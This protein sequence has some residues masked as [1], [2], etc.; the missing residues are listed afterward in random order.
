MTGCAVSALEPG[1]AKT[2]ALGQHAC[3][4]DRDVAVI[5]PEE[6]NARVSPCELTRDLTRA[7]SEVHRH[8]DVG[9]VPLRV[10]GEPPDGQIARV[11]RR[12]RI[13]GLASEQCVVK[14]AVT[15]G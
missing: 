13:V 5:D 9:E 2:E 1:V 12:E 10:I 3:A 4:R 8:L 6:L 7:A 14:L 15:R 11:G